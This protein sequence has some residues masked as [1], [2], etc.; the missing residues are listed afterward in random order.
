MKTAIFSARPY[1][2]SMLSDANR[3]AGHDLRFLEDRLTLQTVALATGCDAVCVFVNDTVDAEVL[4]LLAQQ[5]TR[6]VATRSTGYNHIDVAAAE[7]L[8]IAVV[9]VTD[10]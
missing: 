1:D 8:G 3:E 9:R 4:A 2:K 6:L 5:G 7:R 10:Y